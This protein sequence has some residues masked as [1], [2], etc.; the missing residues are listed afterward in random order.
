MCLKYKHFNE[1]Y[2]AVVD[3]F[4]ALLAMRKF[5]GRKRPLK[6]LPP[7][8]LFLGVN[9]DSMMSKIDADCLGMH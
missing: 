8:N 7:K 9:L 5:L 6:I 3:L 1:C 4:T 2:W